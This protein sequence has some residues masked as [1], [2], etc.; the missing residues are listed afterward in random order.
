MQ[1]KPF[2]GE[3]D[4]PGFL[5]DGPILSHN[6][7]PPPSAAACCDPQAVFQVEQSEQPNIEPVNKNDLFG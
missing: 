3:A 6:K 7:P 5:V 1:G 2:L 4:E